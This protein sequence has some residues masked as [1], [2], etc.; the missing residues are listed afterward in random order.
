MPAI[1]DLAIQ[2]AM[3]YEVGSFWKLSREVELGLINTRSQRRAVGYINDPSDMGG[4]TK[5]G[6]SKRAYPSINIAN[7]RWDQARSIYFKDYWI[8]ACCDKMPYPLAMLHF[9]GSINHGV[10]RA[11]KFLQ[12]AVN[13]VVDGDIGGKTLAAIQV[14]DIMLTCSSICD[15]RRVFYKNIVIA[16][17]EQNKFINGWLYRINH[18]EDYIKN[19]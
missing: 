11:S 2:H 5:F 7:L 4:E 3:L 16:N 15:Q 1:F 17:P 19:L 13:V 9:D 6:I 10:S 8:K 18:I 12:K 14:A